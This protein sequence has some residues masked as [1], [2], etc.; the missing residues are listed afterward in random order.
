MNGDTSKEAYL[1]SFS[2]LDLWQLSHR[3]FS[4]A[5]TKILKW[6]DVTIR[7]TLGANSR[8][9]FH[10]RLIRIAWRF[11]VEQCIGCVFEKIDRLGI[12][13]EGRQFIP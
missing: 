6:A 11:W 5:L 12:I 13:R 9:H 10:H 7:I 4:K 3:S 8:P 1:F 2:P